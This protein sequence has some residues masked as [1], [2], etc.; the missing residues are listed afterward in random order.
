MNR[1]GFVIPVYRHGSTLDYVISSLE[2]FNYLIIVVDDG[3]TGDDKIFIPKAA[4]KFPLVNL[5]VHKTN[6][7]KGRSVNDG[8]KKADEVG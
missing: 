2:K 3:N 1:F 5:V 7:G 8:I 6:G 4:E